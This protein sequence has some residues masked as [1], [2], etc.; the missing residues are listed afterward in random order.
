MHLVALPLSSE[1][2][3][4]LVQSSHELFKCG[5]HDLSPDADFRKLSKI[6]SARFFRALRSAGVKL[7]AL[8]ARE[9][10]RVDYDQR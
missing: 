8:A 4:N 10:L 6:S 3:L 7:M 9:S 1:K 5:F 2:S